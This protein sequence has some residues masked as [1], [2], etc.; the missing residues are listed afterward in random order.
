MAACISCGNLQEP[1]ASKAEPERVALLLLVCLELAEERPLGLH[2]LPD[3]F[4]TNAPARGL[5]H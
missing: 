1:E 2:E 5:G 4:C 3:Y